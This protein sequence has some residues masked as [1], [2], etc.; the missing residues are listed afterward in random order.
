M[1]NY[2][3]RVYDS[4]NIVSQFSGRGFCP[5]NALENAV[6]DGCYIPLLMQLDV[7]CLSETGMEYRFPI[8]RH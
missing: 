5:M 3:F 4:A 1:F 8:A 7:V 6:I 2:Q